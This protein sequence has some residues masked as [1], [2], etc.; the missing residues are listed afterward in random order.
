MPY[1]EV[2]GTVR[3]IRYRISMDGDRFRWKTGSKPLLYGLW[4]LDRDLDH[5]VLVEGE[6]DCHTLWSHGINAV[7]LPGASSYSDDRDSPHLESFSSI[8]IVI[9]PGASG[10]AMLQGIARSRIRERVRLVRLG[11]LKDPSALHVDDPAQFPPRWEQALQAS[12]S[13]TEHAAIDEGDRRQVAWRRC[14]DLVRR[15][16]ILD[17]VYDIIRKRGFVG[18]ERAVKLIYLALTSRVLDRPVSVGVKG[19]SSAG[20]SHLVD[21]T[22]DLFPP[23]AYHTLTAMSERSLA[24]GD[25]PLKHRFLVFAEAEGMMGDISSYLIRSLLSEGKLR[26]ETVEKTPEGLRVRVIEREGPT[27]LIV[28]TT[29][30]GLHPENETRMLSVNVTDT[31]KQTKDILRVLARGPTH[32]DLDEAHAL[33]EWIGLGPDDAVIPY[34]EILVELIPAIAV[35][36]RRDVKLLLNLIKAHAILHQASRERDAG[37]VVAT[38]EDYEVPRDLVA[39][40][41]AQGLEATVSA[42]DRET[43]EAVERLVEGLEDVTYK[44]V[45]QKLGIDKSAASRRCK[46]VMSLGYVQNLEDRKGKPAKLALGD[47]MPED[48]QVLPQVEDLRAATESG[49]TVDLD[50]EGHT[51]SSHI[52]SPTET[53][54]EP[55]IPDIRDPLPQ[56]FDRSGQ[57]MRVHAHELGEDVMVVADNAKPPD[58]NLVVYRAAELPRIAS[59]TAEKVKAAHAVKKA[60]DGELIE[61]IDGVEIPASLLLPGAAVEY[62]TAIVDAVDGGELEAIC[63]KLNDAY[64]AGELND[65]SLKL[66]T[67]AVSKRAKE[68]E[69]AADIE[70]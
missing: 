70:P 8:Y 68:L 5:V 4:R 19:P 35:R 60:F 57:S 36:L 1:R 33:Q 43:V 14:E 65:R 18:E 27:G 66:L 53:T 24:Y 17:D 7:G 20:K 31:P 23:E 64:K 56:D 21:R 6:S 52:P 38:L 12:V 22:L 16:R 59:L 49:C 10:E 46:K 26:Y 62:N 40:L 47:P 28:T 29:R 55:P 63:E 50:S 3:S 2:D 13:W 32:V 37:R 44:A 45:G 54:V 11:E 42:T 48:Q 67:D 41:I 69:D 61:P 58:T 25:E 39:D 30:L 51:P 34:A 15:P 9:E